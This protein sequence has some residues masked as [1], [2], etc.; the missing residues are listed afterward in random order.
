VPRLS[1]LDATFL[2]MDTSTMHMHICLVAVL[3]PSTMPDGY[4]YKKIRRHIESRAP[5]I[6]PF[7]RVL[8]EVPF[9][10]NHPVW[11][12][13]A[14]FDIRRHVHRVR[15]AKPGSLH[16]LAQVAGDIAG[17]PLNRRRPLWDMTVVEGLADDRIGLVA[18]IHHSAMDGTSAVEIMVAFFDLEPLAVE[19]TV[20][21]TADD[22]QPSDAP[23]GDGELMVQAAVD[24]VRSVARSWPLLRRTGTAIADVARGR[25][26]TSGAVGGTPLTAPRTRLNGSLVASREMAF[27]QLSLDDIKLIK[28]TLGV[29]V[30]DVVLATCARALRGYLLDHDDLPDE[31]LLASCPVSIRT[32][33]E[34]G[35]FDNRVSVMFTQL[36]TELTDPI[37]CLRATAAAARAAKSEHEVLGSSTLADWAEVLDPRVLSTV[38]DLLTRYQLGDRLPPVHNLVVSNVAGP[39]FPVYLAGARLEQAYPMGPVIEGAGLNITVLSYCDSVDVGFLASP[40]LVDDLWT[41]ADRI[42]VAFDELRRAAEVESDHPRPAH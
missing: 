28:K 7:R 8:H 6:P 4:S 19:P 9:R 21:A 12:D 33:S 38:T 20:D 37:D 41:M 24:R 29:T 11:V 16:D 42:P 15:L 31:P 36:H 32:E 10:L 27:S 34:A 35:R 1:G 2:Y 5:R 18:K 13:D 14:D 3:D 40:N 25:S 17:R 39:S 26:E 23:P 30:N 22:D